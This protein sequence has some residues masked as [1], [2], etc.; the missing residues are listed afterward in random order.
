[1]NLLLKNKAGFS[2][3]ELMVAAGLLGAI[4]LGV[5]KL[6]ENSTKASKNIEMKDSIIQAHREINDV[7]STSLNCE[8]T[9][10][11]KTV[12]SP[13]YFV[14]QVINGESVAKFQ[15]GTDIAPNVTLQSM[16]IVSIDPNGSVGNSALA[17]VEVVYKKKSALAIGGQELKK[18]LSLNA[19]LCQKLA[20]QK[21]TL[22]EIKSACSGSN[23]TLI[24]SPTLW[25]GIYY[26]NCQ[27]CSTAIDN[28]IESCQS[29]G[30][31][32]GVDLASMSQ[33][34]C[35]SIGGEY[36]ET[37]QTCNIDKVAAKSSCSSLGGEYD[38]N[39]HSCEFSQSSL[40]DFIGQKVDSL[41]P[42]CI[43]NINPCSGLHGKKVGEVIVKQPTTST[44]TWY[45][46]V[47]KAHYRRITSPWAQA[48]WC[49]SNYSQYA[50]CGPNG[51]Q[52]H[53]H[54]S[55]TVQGKSSSITCS[56]N[57]GQKQHGNCFVFDYDAC[58][59]T[60]TETKTDPTTE[61]LTINKC[62]K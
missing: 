40:A 15:V 47:C 45:T 11:D 27:D 17:K 1:M 12:G 2:L 8:S 36:D 28:K 16:K 4:S 18:E 55:C 7:L 53:I 61:E 59:T 57:F 43:L 34:Q 38:E 14:N 41:M 5:M 62:C 48:T 31:G 37:T 10:A 42:S 56:N 51:P 24:D 20:L 44:Y 21:T 58:S 46:R 25:E 22:A 50:H 33:M 6:M 13:I 19:N 35:I 52:V 60:K 39:A 49:G 30:M 9:F 23:K 26:A 29:S 54:E 32:M 3:P